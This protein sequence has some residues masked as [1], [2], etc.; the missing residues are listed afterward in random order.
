MVDVIQELRDQISKANLWS[1]DLCIKRNDYL[2]RAGTVEKQLY[3][4]EEGTMRVFTATEGE[5]QVIR[6]GYPG[7]IITA[8]DSFL[9]GKP[10]IFNLQ[11][12]KK[13]RL[14]SIQVESF[15]KLISSSHE[16]T[17]LYLIILKQFVLQQIEREEDLLTPSPEARYRRVLK[18]SPR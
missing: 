11:A 15:N 12:I 1:K 2:I 7:S 8:L 6:F 9:S 13:C 18:R 16:N 5:E 10:T 14:K 4:I 17:G 3:F